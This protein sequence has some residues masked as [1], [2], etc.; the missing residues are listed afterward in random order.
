MENTIRTESMVMKMTVIGNVQKMQE[1]AGL[2]VS[3][4]EKLEQMSYSDLQ[5]MQETLIPIYN[6]AVK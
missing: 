1:T 6:E 2:R 3:P 4:F 5:E